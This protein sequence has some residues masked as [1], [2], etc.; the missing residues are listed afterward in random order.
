MN[1]GVV[2]P[3]KVNAGMDSNREFVIPVPFACYNV[4]APWT[5]A[6]MCDGLSRVFD[7]STMHALLD[8]NHPSGL[9]R[10]NVTS[11]VD[12]AALAVLV[13]V[14]QQVVDDMLARAHERGS[15]FECA[16]GW[17]KDAQTEWG[18]AVLWRKGVFEKVT[19]T[20]G[21]LASGPFKTQTYT[22]VLLRICATGTMLCVVAVH[23]KAGSMDL[24]PVR[25]RQAQLAVAGAEA[26]FG[27]G[28]APM[29]VPIIIAGDFNSD[30][31]D[32]SSRVGRLMT[33][34]GFSDAG[35]GTHARTIKH[36]GD[37]IFD[38]VYTRGRGV[39][40]CD[41]RVRDDA[42]QGISP[43]LTEGSDHL[44]VLC[45]LELNGTRLEGFDMGFDIQPKVVPAQGHLPPQSLVPTS[46]RA[47]CHSPRASS[48]CPRAS[49]G[50]KWPA[51]TSKGQPCL[52]CSSNDP[53]KFCFQH[54]V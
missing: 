40:T 35:A 7:I 33:G 4:L 44:P 36:G 22:A 38:Y 30:R 5:E 3:V 19:S 49:D 10:A 45:T 34:L 24:E 6:D 53:G 13:E 20:V 11:V 50:K 25:E 29:E 23:L 52:R 16:I 12:D 42:A 48:H 31:R 8:Y 39:R 9:R 37:A 43:N 1:K 47:P 27:D 21:S 17:R 41:Y 32:Q 2:G 15:P 18:G 26:L 46:H 28:G 51:M 14:E 54:A